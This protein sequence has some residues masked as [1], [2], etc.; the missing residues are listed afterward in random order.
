MAVYPFSESFHN[1]EH[2]RRLPGKSASGRPEPPPQQPRPTLLRQPSE[3]QRRR[4]PPQLRQQQLSQLQLQ[5]RHEH[6]LST[7]RRAEHARPCQ[8]GV[9]TAH[10]A[11]TQTQRAE[12]EVI[13]RVGV[14]HGSRRDP[15]WVA[16]R[17]IFY[18]VG[19]G[20]YEPTDHKQI[21]PG[22]FETCCAGCSHG[23]PPCCV[24][25]RSAYWPTRV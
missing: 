12:F 18:D 16:A 4:R 6:H 14:Q 22:P 19:A 3:R 25:V 17:P 5:L 24:L 15:T 8:C 1:P 21:V 10:A 13:G 7:G 2:R 20:G 9:H 23:E 11:Q